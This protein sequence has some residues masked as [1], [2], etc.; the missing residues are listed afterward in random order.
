MRCPSYIFVLFVVFV[1]LLVAATVSL[2]ARYLT[3]STLPW[4]NCG[5]I[6]WFH[7]FITLSSIFCEIYFFSAHPTVNISYPSPL[8][9]KANLIPSRDPICCDI[10]LSRC[11]CEVDVDVDVECIFERYHMLAIFQWVFD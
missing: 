2:V 7:G 4:D 6:V 8:A 3:R 9:L 5:L 11:G 1:L 10:P